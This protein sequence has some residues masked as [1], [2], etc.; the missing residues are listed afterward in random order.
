MTKMIKKST[1]QNF[2]SLMKDL[3][4]DTT[5]T[6]LTNIET[7]CRG[8]T[9]FHHSSYRT[10]TPD[11]R[12][13]I[14]SHEL[15]EMSQIKVAALDNYSSIVLANLFDAKVK[16]E[17]IRRKRKALMP[18]AIGLCP[19]C[20]QFTFLSSPDSLILFC[21]EYHIA[22]SIFSLSFSDC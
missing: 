11:E 13:W 9:M 15:R 18:L 16:S 17:K 20:R 12:T 21:Q 14:I 5:S 2:T 6:L 4:V 22:H 1:S 7:L 19:I 10:K 3:K 8:K